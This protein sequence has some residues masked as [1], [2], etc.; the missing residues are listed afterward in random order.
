MLDGRDD[1]VLGVGFALG[2]FSNTSS[3]TY[4]EDYESILEVY[5]NAPITP[6]LNISPGIQ[7]VTNP[8]GV[9]TASDAI[10]FGLRAQVT[11]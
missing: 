1:D 6:W 4:P 2:T 3:S 10:V 11:F 8:G 9:K 5:Y 7:Y